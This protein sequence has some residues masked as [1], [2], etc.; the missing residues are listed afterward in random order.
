VVLIEVPE[1]LEEAFLFIIPHLLRLGKVHL[2]VRTQKPRREAMR[3]K[4]IGLPGCRVANLVLLSNPQSHIEAYT[5]RD[6]MSFE[7]MLLITSQKQ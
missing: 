5:D 7:G 1:F 4:N 2:R 3:I 6:V